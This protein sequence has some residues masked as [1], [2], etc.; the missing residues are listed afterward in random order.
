ML[1][2]VTVHRPETEKGHKQVVHG[3]LLSNSQLPPAVFHSDGH[4]PLLISLVII[5]YSCLKFVPWY[6]EIT[7]LSSCHSVK[8]ITCFQAFIS[9]KIVTYNIPFISIGS[10]L[11]F[12]DLVWATFTRG[13]EFNT[14]WIFFKPDPSLN[15]RV[16]NPC[17]NLMQLFP[18]FGSTFPH[19]CL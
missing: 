8:T 4:G 18:Y 10:I 3:S 7:R 5:I 11:I 1:L 13:H 6:D 2:R 15:T 9:D 12:S 16:C 17:W 14:E 19:R